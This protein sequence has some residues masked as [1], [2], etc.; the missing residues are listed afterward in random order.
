[1]LVSV[2]GGTGFV[3]AHSVAAI[4][5]KGHRVRM[6]VRDTAKAGPAPE[7]SP[8]PARPSPRPSVTRCAGCTRA[9]TCRPGRRDWNG[10][11]CRP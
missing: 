8:T 3:G 5:R 9:A 1:M 4:V 11:A 2:T 7:A 6:L 10:R